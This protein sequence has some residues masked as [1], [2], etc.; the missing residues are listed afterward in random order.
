MWVWC[1]G[2]QHDD[3]EED[4]RLLLC[5]CCVVWVWVVVSVIARRG[6]GICLIPNTAAQQDE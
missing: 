6:K 1:V 3:D 5:V 2:G 4:E